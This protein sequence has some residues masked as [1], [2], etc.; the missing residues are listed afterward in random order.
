MRPDQIMSGSSYSNR[1]GTNVRSVVAI[2]NEH[3]PSDWNDQPRV[4]PSEP[5]VL[6]T[7]DGQQHSQ[8]L[9]RFA[10]WAD[11]AA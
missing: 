6:Y 4:L 5:G 8:Y 3:R 7:Q 9:S 11:R 2:G 1:A 10:K